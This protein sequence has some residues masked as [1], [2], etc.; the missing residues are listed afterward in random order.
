M[1]LLDTIRQLRLEKERLDRAIALLEELQ[2]AQSSEESARPLEKGRGRKSMPEA[3]RKIV[4]QRMKR[5][6]EKR[7]QDTSE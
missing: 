4:S 5:Y 7:H 3:E 2:S 6:W 1:D